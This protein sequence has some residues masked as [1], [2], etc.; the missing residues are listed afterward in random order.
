[1]TPNTPLP[2]PACGKSIQPPPGQL[3]FACVHCRQEI[4]V[5]EDGT[6]TVV[7]DPA[8]FRRRP[9]GLNKPPDVFRNL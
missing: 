6:L 2:C 7:V 5:E 8:D 3:V 4:R 9:E 1:M